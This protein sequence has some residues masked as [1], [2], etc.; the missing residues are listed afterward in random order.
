MTPSTP[1]RLPTGTHRVDWHNVLLVAVLLAVPIQG[2]LSI[3]FDRRGPHWDE[4]SHIAWGYAYLTQGAFHLGNDTPPLVHMLEALPLL[5]IPK[6]TLPP[7]W[8]RLGQI[9]IGDQ[10]VNQNGVPASTII[11]WGRVPSVLLLTLLTWLVYKW[12]REMGGAGGGLLAALFCATDPSLLGRAGFIGTDIGVA[13]FAFLAVRWFL[14]Y[15]ES[16]GLGTGALAGLGLGLALVTKFSSVFLFPAGAL[17]LTIWIV[18][19]WS[20]VKSA[21][22][23]TKGDKRRKLRREFR[24]ALMARLRGVGWIVIIAAFVIALTYRVTEVNNFWDGLKVQIGRASSTYINFML[25]EFSEKGWWYYY[26][27]A[28]LVKTPIP[29]LVATVLSC[30]RFGWRE[31][32]LLAAPATLFFLACRSSVQMGPRYILPLYPFLAVFAARLAAQSWVRTVIGRVVMGFLIAWQVATSFRIFPSYPMFYNEIVALAYGSADRGYKILMDF[33]IGV[34]LAAIRD[35]IKERK[36][37]QI[38]MVAYNWS[39]RRPYVVHADARAILSEEDQRDPRLVL[40]A[41]RIV[42]IVQP[43]A[44]AW[45]GAMKPEDRL[46]WLEERKP[47]AVLAH[48]MFAYDLTGREKEIEK[49]L[50]YR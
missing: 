46:D 1:S 17:L 6:V 45:R 24:D 41:G 47:D 7:N 15:L 2:L 33:D 42:A 26:P 43:L 27:L 4:S 8:D 18:R 14:G 13:L 34:N 21:L 16:P 31:A 49:L 40:E 25:G 35:H 30:W 5:F 32:Q 48:T 38:M 37:G 22:Q 50:A 39:S 10:F 20:R 9:A 28:L 12:G 36:V 23:E 11:F 29:V 3:S 44:Y 19:E